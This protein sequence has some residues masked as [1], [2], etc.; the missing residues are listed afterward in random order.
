M[1]IR[2]FIG[3]I[4]FAALQGCAKIGSPTGGVKDVMPPEYLSGIPENRSVNFTGKRVDINFNEYIQLKNQNTE[5]VI[6]PPMKEKPLV[7]VR[8]KSIRVSFNEDLLPSTTYTLNFGNSISDLN[9]GNLLPDFEFV[10][11]TGNVIDS[12]SVTGKVV[13]A[14]TNEPDKDI[15]MMVMLYKNLSDSAP[16][17]E[18]PRYYTRANEA[19]LFAI[20]NIDADTFRI[21]AL[22]DVNNNLKY[23]PGLEHIAFSDSFLVVNPATVTEQT[24]IK[25][26]IKIITG[27]DETIRARRRDTVNID[28]IIAPG[29][30]VNAVNVKLHS[31][32]EQPKR[33]IVTSRT[34]DLPEY[35]RFTFNRP[36]YDSLIIDPLNFEGT[37]GWSLPEISVSNDTLAYWVTDSNIAKL[38]TLLLSISYQTIDSAG[39]LFLK[40]DTVRLRKASETARSG[41]STRRD[42][43]AEA[44]PVSELVLNSSVPNRGNLNLN[45]NPE[46]GVSR[47]IFELNPDSI[48][49]GMYMDTLLL[50]QKFSIK[51]RGLRNFSVSTQWKEDTPYRIL[52]KPGAINDIYGKTNDSLEIRFATRALDY[53]GRILLNFSAHTYPMIVQVLNEKGIVVRSSVAE[54]PG[55]IT[56]EYLLPGKYY[57]KAIHDVNGNGKWDTGNLLEKRQPERTFISGKPQ[58]L[59]SNWDWENSWSIT[60]NSSE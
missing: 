42:R 49:F 8:E 38:D 40:T 48:E 45:A 33:V 2:I 39:I 34:R 15:R 32:T 56:F 9:E 46:F 31:F 20:N 28:T 19:G 3:L 6:S 58:Q 30:K 52:F 25:D 17:V 21:I 41:R 54:K 22:N 53:Y 50:P 35:F 27:A 5:V 43:Q 16:L 14:F 24:F 44:T 4:I 13:N 51:Q 55:V 29:R 7:R 26:T 18:I 59:R 12:L 37:S 23:D 60:E 36:L 1:P 10:I 11:S 47:P 57:F